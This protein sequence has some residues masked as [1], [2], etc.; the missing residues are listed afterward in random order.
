MVSTKLHRFLVLRA[1]TGGVRIEPRRCS[2][3]KSV[4]ANEM[5]VLSRSRR[6]AV[7]H[8]VDSIWPVGRIGCWEFIHIDKRPAGVR[9]YYVV[10][11]VVAQQSTGI[12]QTVGVLGG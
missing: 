8:D 5:R 3:L 6:V 1:N 12:C 2:A 11:Q 7:P 4:A 9:T 10:H